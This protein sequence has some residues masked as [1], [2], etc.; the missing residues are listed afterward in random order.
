[1]TSNNHRSHSPFSIQLAVDGSDNSVDAALLVRSLPLPPSSRVAVVG[2]LAPGKSY[3]EDTL[4]AGLEKIQAIIS[5]GG[6]EST[7]C[8]LHGHTAKTLLEFADETQP[9]LIVVGA[10]GLHT[11]LKILL[12][13]V[14]Q[15]VVEYARWPVLV[16]RAPF[17]GVQRVLLAADGSP[18][19][20]LSAEYLAQF[21]LPM[22]TEVSIIHVLP[23]LPDPSRLISYMGFS[24]H[25]YS[26]FPAPAELHI[27]ER[28]KEI[29]ERQA[30]T[31]VRDV[32]QI[33]EES[34]IKA[35][36]IV[37]RGDPANAILEHV[38]AEKIDLVVAGSRGL[39][40]I[41][42]WWWGSV[43]RKLVHYAACSMLFVRGR[44]ERSEE[45]S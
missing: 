39:S 4:R 28:Q 13:G 29:E 27:D 36:G 23:P 18:Y 14:A 24:P 8:M 12:G 6:I 33:L 19:S 21:P 10:R 11:T 2:V 3:Y 32:R 31:I 26:A 42:G 20:Q 41:K 5:A 35:K 16:V 44:P 43:S 38:L 45:L 17:N 30:Q 40:A 25:P 7:S 22:Q 34:N 37:V 15:Q 9:D 1:M